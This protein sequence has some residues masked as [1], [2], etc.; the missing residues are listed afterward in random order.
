[1][2]VKNAIRAG[3]A[4][5]A[6]QR[7]S[8]PP[9]INRQSLI[10]LL[11]PLLWATDKQVVRREILKE[12]QTSKISTFVLHYSSR[13]F[14]T[15]VRQWNATELFEFQCTLNQA[16]FWAVRFVLM[17]QSLKKTKEVSFYSYGQSSYPCRQWNKPALSTLAVIIC[18][19]L[20]VC[21]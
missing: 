1:M 17:G 14:G 8:V 13:F 11:E 16:S 18:W 20:Y 19:N 5:S 12:K 21:L 2:D 6:Q 9:L 4:S 3:N 15:Y 7:V 10:C